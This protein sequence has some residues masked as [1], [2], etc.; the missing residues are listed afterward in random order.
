MSLFCTHQLWATVTI[1]SEYMLEVFSLIYIPDTIELLLPLDAVIGA[2]VS[3]CL[4]AAL[5]TVASWRHK[6]PASYHYH[7]DSGSD[8]MRIRPGV[9]CGRQGIA[10]CQIIVCV[11]V[12]LARVQPVS[13]RCRG[14]PVTTVRSEISFK[15][16]AV[17]ILGVMMWLPVNAA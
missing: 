5:L 1:L 12:L 9:Q 16:V 15:P 2:A 4:A 10:L 7:W 6:S 17:L 14:G 13:D 11:I 3:P 8:K